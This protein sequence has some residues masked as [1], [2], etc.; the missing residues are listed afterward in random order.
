[1][2]LNVFYNDKIFGASCESVKLM[3][4]LALRRQS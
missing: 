1:M 2:H 4:K 3:V